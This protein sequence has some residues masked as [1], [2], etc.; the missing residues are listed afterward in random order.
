MTRSQAR[1]LR[2]SSVRFDLEKLEDRQLLAADVYISEFGA[3]NEATLVDEDG[4]SPDWIEIFNAGPDTANLEG[5]YLTDSNAELRKWS[6]PARELEPGNFLIVYA[7]DK[8]RSEPTGPLHANFRLTSDGEFLGLTRDT[9]DGIEVVSAFSPE[10]PSQ[11][12]DISY[13]VSQNVVETTYLPPAAPARLFFPNDDNLGP[14]W[15]A[16]DFNDA[17][18]LPA[19]SSIGYQTTVPGFTVQDSH[20]TGTIQNLTNA[21]NVLNGNGL[22]SETTAITPVVNFYDFTGAAGGPANFSGDLLFPN[23]TNSDDNDFAVRAT[24][25]ILISE[26]GTYTFGVNSDDGSR[27]RINNRT[28]INDNT[29][30]APR[31]TFGSISLDPGEHEL[32]LIF[33]ERG[34]GA[35]VELFAARGNF[36]SFNSQFELVGDTE[37]GGLPVFTSPSGATSPFGSQFASDVGGQMLD[38]STD[39]FMRVPFVMNDPESLDSLTLRMNYDDGFVAYL[40]GSE[41]ARR[42]APDSP[43][44]PGNAVATSD[45]PRLESTFAESIDVTPFLGLLESGTNVLSIHGLNESIDSGEFL[46][47]AELA[48]VAVATGDLL[49]FPTPTPGTYNPATGVE[50][51]LTDEVSFSRE[52]GFYEEPFQVTLSAKTSG[53]T[54]RFTTDGTEPTESSSLY[55]SPISIDATSTIRARAFKPGLDPS[56]VETQTYIFLEDVVDQTRSTALAAGFPSST[57]INGQSI[58][59]GMDPDIVN[60]GVWG[61]QMEEALTQIPTMSIVMDIDDLM[62]SNTGIFVNAGSH[63]REWERPAS[64]ELINPDGSQ[65]FQVDMGL[66]IRGGFS[67]SGNN[68]KHAFRLF[69]RDE[70]GGDSKLRYPLFGDEGVDEFDKIDLRTTQNYSW[71]FQ[72]DSR[73][74]FVRDVFSRDLQ[75]D[76]GNPYTRSRF[77]H[78]YINTQYWGL[79]QT[80][81]RSEARYAASYFGGDAEDYDVVKSAGSSGGYQNEAT[82]GTLEAYRRLA[83]Y[84]YQAGGLSDANQEDY[85]RAQGMNL[86]GTVNPDY[87][88]LLDVDNLIDYMVITYFTSDAD[89]PGSKFTRP[90]VNNYYGIFN[91]EDPDGFKFFEHD[92]EHSLDTGNAAGANYNMVTPLTTGGSQYRYFNPHWM[93]EQLANT[94]TEYLIRFMDRVTEL[95]TPGGLLTPEV[96]TSMIDDRAAEFDMAIIAE[97][98]RW[99][100]AKRNSPYTKNNWQAAVNSTKNWLEDRIPVFLNQLSSVN[101]Y[102]NDGVP[103]FNV[104][105]REQHGGEITSADTITLS[106]GEPSLNYDQGLISARR[107]WNYLDDGSNQGTAWRERDF[108]DSSWSRGRAELGY[109]DGNEVTEVSFGPNSSDKYVTTYFRSLP[110]NVDDPNAYAGLQV[111]LRRDDGAVVY[112]N[113]QE[114]VR[115]NMPSGNINYRTSASG[116]AGGGDESTFFS[117]SVDPSSLVAGENVVAVEVHQNVGGAGRVTSSDISFDLALAA[118]LGGQAGGLTNVFYTTDGSD[119]RLPG[120]ELNPT[121]VTVPEDGIV[122][123]RSAELTARRRSGNS[124]GPAVTALFTVEGSNLGDLNEDDQLN[125]ADVDL[126]TAAIRDG[127]A[128]ARFDLNLDSRVD[129]D[130]LT[131]MI[132]SIFKTQAGDTDLDGDVDFA[133]FLVVSGNFGNDQSGW[134]DGNF[135]LDESV[136]FAD[137]LI[138]S[139]QFGFDAE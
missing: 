15:T 51:F 117:F 132:E 73:N 100:D 81:E 133:D 127:Q 86:D 23:D 25:K 26:G 14:S 82:D 101:W 22:A 8:D 9:D 55:N 87:E 56:R 115:S 124:W 12:P 77:Y 30:H 103:V 123:N 80:Q 83:D 45:R 17:S 112:I 120:G 42:N 43:T 109:G 79:F 66:R 69:F 93:H 138:L 108:D 113:G 122:L 10:Y 53:T 37:N 105:G 121:A 139:A 119:P 89:G 57:S 48:E 46:M 36:T 28:V 125:S 2:R 95:V 33:F 65:G 129:D 63:G 3:V 24:G 60:S 85:M 78:L 128:D 11:F 68:P 98:A 72:G 27:L 131:F 39:V 106:L 21:L 41:I 90:R 91:R 34:G 52:H 137:F 58:D 74:A 47:H 135:D 44:V 84:F 134:S 104:N 5:W 6:F 50:G 71:S 35:E 97:S 94:N 126:L 61:P 59:L 13:G 70:Y 130:D 114:V 102:P 88:R 67:R 75:G 1:V 96:T 111:Q 62:R 136:L 7:S 54:I 4:D 92:S 16:V 99:G 29:L 116:V 20:S 32:E 49:Y 19:T 40:N 38:V 76:M 118:A 18:W 64:L 107:S 31:D 110:F